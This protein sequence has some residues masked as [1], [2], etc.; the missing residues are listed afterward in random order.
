[1][2]TK[3]E[4]EKFLNTFQAKLK[5]FKI[6]FRDDRGKNTRALAE[7]EITPA[8]RENVIRNITVSD[9]SEGPVKDTLNKYGEIWVFGKDVKKKRYISRLRLDIRTV[10]QYVFLSTRQNIR[11][12]ILL[13]TKNYE[14][15][16][17]RRRSKID[18]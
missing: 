15:S 3:D 9:Y 5:I 2:A 11:S 16:I 1:M 12:Y 4:V 10:L 13:R 8:Y 14:K 7:L 6:I 17:Y 18:A